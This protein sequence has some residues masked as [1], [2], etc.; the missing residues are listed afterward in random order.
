MLQLTRNSKGPQTT[1][2]K[3]ILVSYKTEE[4]D[5]PKAEITDEDIE[6][7]KHFTNIK[8]IILAENLITN[9]GARTICENLVHL[10]KLFI[11]NNNITD[12]GIASIY[13][14]ANLRCL[15]LRVNHIGDRGMEHI[16]RLTELTQLSVSN[17]GVTDEG[18]IGIEK[19][20]NLRYLD[21][22]SNQISNKGGLLICKL[23]T[24]SNLYLSH[25][26]IQAIVAAKLVTDLPEIKVLD[27]RFNDIGKE[28]KTG[29]KDKC[30]TELQLFL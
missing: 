8:T 10:R 7:L 23:K 30:R 18:M 12:E 9:V 16:C 19:L 1:T 26:K 27:L 24:L 29:V 13:K 17:N 25:N 4:V 11:N 22:T 20:T 14:L 3:D 28:D 21:M 2:I 5:L 15:D 6:P